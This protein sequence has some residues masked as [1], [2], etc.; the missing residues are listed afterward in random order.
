[1]DAATQ[2]CLL[3]LAHQGRLSAGNRSGSGGWHGGGDF[4][5]IDGDDFVF[6]AHG[7]LIA[8]AAGDNIDEHFREVEGAIKDAWLHLGANPG[9]HRNPAARRKEAHQISIFDALFGGI[10]RM[11]GQGVFGDDVHVA[12]APGHGA[13]IVVL[14]EA[15]GSQDERIFSAVQFEFP[16]FLEIEEVEFAEA[17]LEGIQVE[18]GGA[19]IARG[20]RPLLSLVGQAFPGGTFEERHNLGDLGVFEGRRASLINGQIVEEGMMNPPHA[21]A[22]ELT[23]RV[24]TIAFGEGWRIR[25]QLPLVFDDLNSPQPDF[26]IIRG[27][28]RGATGHPTTAELVIEIADSSLNYDTTVKAELYAT[29]GIP[30]YWVIDLEGRNMQVFRDPVPLPKGLGA[31]AYQSHTT[32]AATDTVSPLAVTTQSIRVADLLP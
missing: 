30:E 25:S 4:L 31:T 7:V 28:V 5:H 8:L 15:A 19:D 13:A 2:A 24:I 6:R 22:M 1:M 3:Q 21:I 18:P 17:T 11:D 26:A 29:A 16:G 20:N 14:E 10:V 23:T 9:L 32:L 27:S 12:G